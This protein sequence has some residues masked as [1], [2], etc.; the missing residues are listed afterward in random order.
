MVWLDFTKKNCDLPFW[1]DFSSKTADQR[2][3]W[4]SKKWNVVNIHSTT[5]LAGLHDTF[6]TVTS[7]SC[8]LTSED[9]SV[10]KI[11]WHSD[12][13][14]PPN[15]WRP[16]RKRSQDLCW[17][18]WFVASATGAPRSLSSTCPQIAQFQHCVNL[19]ARERDAM[20]PNP[21]TFI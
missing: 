18:P 2:W 11:L 14:K 6:F 13:Y 5:P 7:K 12:S 1:D 9:L 17:W 20:W 16:K 10:T 21:S 4:P 19:K 3:Q 15:L 8:F